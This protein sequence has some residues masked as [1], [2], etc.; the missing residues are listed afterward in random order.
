[1]KHLHRKCILTPTHTRRVSQPQESPVSGPSSRPDPTTSASSSETDDDEDRSPVRPTMD[2]PRNLIHGE[3]ELAN[4]ANARPLPVVNPLS[5]PQLSPASVQNPAASSGL[6]LQQNANAV[7]Y[8]ANLPCNNFY[9][10][11]ATVGL[12]PIPSKILKAIQNKE[13]VDFSALLPNYLY[14]ADTQGNGSFGF[15][16]DPSG[17]GELFP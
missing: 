4:Q 13:Y 17:E 1:M 7:V 5:L 3:I 16:F 8:S 14:D 10:P 11:S 2:E 9:F 15:Q 12:P 6:N